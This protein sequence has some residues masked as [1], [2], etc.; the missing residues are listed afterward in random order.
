MNYYILLFSFVS[1][2]FSQN[3]AFLN[4]QTIAITS[5][6]FF[7]SYQIQMLILHFYNKIKLIILISNKSSEEKNTKK[8]QTKNNIFNSFFPQKQHAF[9]VSSLK[10]NKK[11]IIKIS[12][13]FFS[14]KG[15][16]STRGNIIALILS[17]KETKKRNYQ[18]LI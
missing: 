9:S 2:Y 17:L 4:N 8:K 3:K 11:G 18:D 16:C 12:S 5:S 6:S 13:S 10:G 14:S 15:T 7:F 1:K